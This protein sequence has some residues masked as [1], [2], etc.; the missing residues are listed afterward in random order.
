MQTQL[1]PRLRAIVLLSGLALLSACAAA[2]AGAAG[3]AAG[4]YLTDQGAQ[5]TVDGSLSTVDTR[6]QAVLSDMGITVTERKQEENG[7]EYHGTGNGMD[8]N[9]ELDGGDSGTTV[10]KASARKNAVEWDKDYAR[11]IV[12]RIASH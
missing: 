8:V 4:I 2:A 10:V 6:T 7:F 9:V 3:A 5:G 11:T 1:I 12:A